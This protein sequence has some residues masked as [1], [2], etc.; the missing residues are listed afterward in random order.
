M[1]RLF[2]AFCLLLLLRVLLR[3]DALAVAGLALVFFTFS[4]GIVSRGENLAVEIVTPAG[5]GGVGAHRRR[6]AGFVT[7]SEET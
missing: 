1:N 2:V 7:L 6:F 4:F 5:H 3:K